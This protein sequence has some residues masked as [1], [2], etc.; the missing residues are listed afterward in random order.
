MLKVLFE[1]LS[2]IHGHVE[3]FSEDRNR[4]KRL[5]LEIKKTKQHN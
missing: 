2:N 4:K 1:K 3:N 5:I